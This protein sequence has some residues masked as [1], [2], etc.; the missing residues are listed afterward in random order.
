M[1]SQAKVNLVTPVLIRLLRTFGA[2]DQLADEVEQFNTKHGW[3]FD[4][5]VNGRGDSFTINFKL[6]PEQLTQA[7]NNAYLELARQ[8]VLEDR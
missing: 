4:R 6:R 7:W 1:D 5:M 2:S 3:E 8:D